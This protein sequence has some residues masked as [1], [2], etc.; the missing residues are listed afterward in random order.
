[1][2]LLNARTA[3]V[4]PPI[5]AVTAATIARKAYRGKGMERIERSSSE[6]RGELPAWRASFA[7]D[8]TIRIH[9][10]TETGRL[11]FVRTGTWRLNDLF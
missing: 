10:A 1:M 4:P 6:Y 8:D 9:V 5:D 2:R 11:T 7:D 3:T